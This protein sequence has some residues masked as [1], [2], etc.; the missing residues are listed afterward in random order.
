MSFPV[1]KMFPDIRSPLLLQPVFSRLLPVPPQGYFTSKTGFQ[2]QVS[3]WGR[4]HGRR[5]FSQAS[6]W[7]TSRNRIIWSKDINTLR[8]SIHSAKLL[9]KNSAQIYIL[10]SSSLFSLFK[11]VNN[12]MREKLSY[13]FSL[14]SLVLIRLNIFFKYLYPLWIFY[15]CLY[16]HLF[17]NIS[18]LF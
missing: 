14:H 3:R 18:D 5:G 15:S 13:W 16:Y 2:S 7:Y 17:T 10:T 9:R 11:I 12:L 8:H 1:V 6:L 4:V